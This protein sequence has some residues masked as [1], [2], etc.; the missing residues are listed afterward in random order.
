MII[1]DI[2]SNHQ[3]TRTAAGVAQLL[4]VPSPFSRSAT[5]YPDS[6][7][8]DQICSNNYVNHL[9]RGRSFLALPLDRWFRTAVQEPLDQRVAE[10]DLNRRQVRHSSHGRQSLDGAD[11]PLVST[12]KAPVVIV[13]DREG[14]FL[15][16][17]F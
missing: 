5:A 3:M 15:L 10:I 8:P 7:R 6:A 13:A 9:G 17:A 1:Y 2:S 11:E 14:A 4:G 16:E 12:I